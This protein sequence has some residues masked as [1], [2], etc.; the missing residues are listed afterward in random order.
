MT[1]P[2]NPPIT[3]PTLFIAL[4]DFSARHPVELDLRQGDLLLC[5]DLSTSTPQHPNDYFQAMIDKTKWGL[6]PKALVQKH[7]AP[8]RQPLPMSGWLTKQSLF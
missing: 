5:A 1:Q 8:T 6:V 2:P 4:S 7:E 3:S